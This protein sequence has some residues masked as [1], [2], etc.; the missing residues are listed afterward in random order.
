MCCAQSQW[1]GG[2]TFGSTRRSPLGSAGAPWTTCS[3][4]GRFQNLYLFIF[5][6]CSPR[7]TDATRCA[8]VNSAA[9]D[10]RIFDLENFPWQVWEQFLK[11]EFG[12]GMELDSLKSS[13]P[14]EVPMRSAREVDE[15]FDAIS[16][17]KSHTHTLSLSSLYMHYT[18]L[19]NTTH[20]LTHTHSLSLLFTNTTH[21]HTNTLQTPHTLT[22]ALS[23]NHTHTHTRTE[24]R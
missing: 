20:S 24:N 23:L 18:H 3:P 13:H 6:L 19:K 4:N 7:T 2:L 10:R 1:S 21:T 17:S 12:R 8:C 14:I 16:Y 11:G 5:A 15:I 22:H 9:G